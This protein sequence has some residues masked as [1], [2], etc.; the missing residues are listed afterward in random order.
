MKPT[1]ICIWK[2]NIEREFRKYGKD[3]DITELECYEC[4]V[5]CE[6]YNQDCKKYAPRQPKGCERSKLEDLPVGI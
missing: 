5:E 2:D 3:V 4:L 6:G 1:H